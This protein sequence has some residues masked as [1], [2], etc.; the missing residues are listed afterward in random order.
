MKSWIAYL[1]LFLCVV[2]CFAGLY[3]GLEAHYDFRCWSYGFTYS[4]FS[5]GGVGCGDQSGLEVWLRDLDHTIYKPA[6]DGVEI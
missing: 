1:L 3:L 5:L 2:S 6:V 4:S